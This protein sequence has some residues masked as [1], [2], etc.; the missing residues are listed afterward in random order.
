MLVL[1]HHSRLL[2]QLPPV[3]RLQRYSDRL[4]IILKNIAPCYQLDTQQNQFSPCAIV[5][6]TLFVYETRPRL[7]IPPS[8]I[9]NELDHRFRPLA[10]LPISVHCPAPSTIH[11]NPVT[12]THR[13]STQLILAVRHK[14]VTDTPIGYGSSTHPHYS[15]FDT[16]GRASR[17][18]PFDTRR[19]RTSPCA[20]TFDTQEQTLPLRS[21]ILLLSP[22]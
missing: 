8:L 10:P 1:H 14:L 19:N 2:R 3:P 6:N 5:F 18:A 21:I 4:P 17:P 16:Q 7:A 15:N 22:S 11:S 20:T 9:L 12:G 13:Y